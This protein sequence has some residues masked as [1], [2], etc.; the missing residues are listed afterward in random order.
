MLLVVVLLVLLSAGK[1]YN[2]VRE[3]ARR[4]LA[5]M[6][7]QELQAALAALEEAWRGYQAALEEAGF[8]LDEQAQRAWRSASLWLKTYL[9]S[10]GQLHCRSW[11]GV[12]QAGTSHSSALVFARIGEFQRLNGGWNGS[13]EEPRAL[14]RPG[15]VTGG[16]QQGHL[17][18]ASKATQL[19]KRLLGSDSGPAFL[20]TGEQAG[21]Y[22]YCRDW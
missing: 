17:A 16:H 2:A 7:Q 4:Q 12:Q 8:E 21:C 15:G 9:V 10:G 1:N 22:Y 13:L 20:R 3:E 19:A 18:Q 11:G 6:D 14:A 5:A